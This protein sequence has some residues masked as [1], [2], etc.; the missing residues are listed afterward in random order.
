MCNSSEQR[1][2]VE[3]TVTQLLGALCVLTVQISY[4]SA[5]L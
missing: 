1:S 5:D 3:V 4:G 2:S